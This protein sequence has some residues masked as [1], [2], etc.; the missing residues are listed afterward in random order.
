MSSSTVSLDIMGREFRVACSQEEKDSLRQAADLFSSKLK[1][2][3][4]SGG[5]V[6]L[7]KIAVLAGLNLAHEF[8][9]LN[10]EVKRHSLVMDSR[11]EDL[12]DKLDGI[13]AETGLE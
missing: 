10:N 9:E 1:E 12:T 8:L 6:G 7:D 4:E 3:K 13:I 5:L 2:V 11:L